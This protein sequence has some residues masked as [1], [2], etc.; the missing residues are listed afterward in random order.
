MGI[1]S[2]LVVMTSN[3]DVFEILREI[4]IAIAPLLKRWKRGDGAMP[5]KHNS[6]NDNG[7]IVMDFITQNNESRSL[8]INFKCDDD[9]CDYNIPE[10]IGNKIILSLG[11][12]GQ[13]EEILQAIGLSLLKYG[14]VFIRVN[15]STD[16]FTEISN[17]NLNIIF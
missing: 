8:F 17:T 1:D 16:V 7:L 14:K 15:D 3:K 6:I 10:L 4:E 12:W 13:N 9:Y 11:Y 2:N 5:K